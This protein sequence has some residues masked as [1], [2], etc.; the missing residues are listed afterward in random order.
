MDS[1]EN[2]KAVIWRFFGG[3]FLSIFKGFQ[4]LRFYRGLRCP[5][6]REKITVLTLGGFFLRFSIGF[7]VHLKT[8]PIKNPKNL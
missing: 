8:T 4:V 5:L 7:R 1:W 2:L 6:K 3:I